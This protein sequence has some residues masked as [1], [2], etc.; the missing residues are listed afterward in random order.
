MDAPE[1]QHWRSI[2]GTSMEITLT[3]TPQSLRIIGEGLME[4]P[5]RISA[6]IIAELNRQVVAQQKTAEAPPLDKSVDSLT[7]AAA[8]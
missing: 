1:G 4:L 5:Y 8:R 2:L 3:V 6:P 7:D